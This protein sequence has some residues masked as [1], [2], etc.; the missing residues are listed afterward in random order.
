MCSWLPTHCA[1]TC[2]QVIKLIS[3]V[4]ADFADGEIGQQARAFDTT[5]TIPEYM[6][7][8]FYKTATLI[9]ASCKSA[10]VFSDMGVDVKNAMF[11][12][13][14]HLGLAFQVVD[15]ILDYT[16]SSAQLGKPQV[17]LPPAYHA[18]IFNL[19]NVAGRGASACL[20]SA[21]AFWASCS[22]MTSRWAVL[23]PSGLSRAVL[24]SLLL[25][26]HG[27]WAMYSRIIE[28]HC[29][30]AAWHAQCS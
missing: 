18:L 4:I 20:H 29:L 11:E 15:D 16:Q 22:A 6:D 28:L 17:H 27:R 7:K 21:S 5:L 12:Y 26:P 3:Q 10:A 30:C 23:Y 14:R 25:L 1:A 19:F 8:S 2:A 13:G 24:L 9:A